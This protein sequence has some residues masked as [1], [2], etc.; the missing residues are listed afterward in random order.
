MKLNKK[1]TVLDERELQEMYQ[2]EHFGLWLMYALL[3]AVILVQ[4]F[5]GAEMK[6][7]AGEMIVLIASSI[8]MII[9]NVRRGIWDTDSRPSMRGNAGYAAGVGVCVSVLQMALRG[10]LPAAL[11]TGLCTML[12]V[13]AALTALMQYMMKKQAQQEKELDND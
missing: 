13:F 8:A 5:M 11:L 1:Q 9:A 2:A 12:L 3:C 10:N 7:M 4:M 6:Q